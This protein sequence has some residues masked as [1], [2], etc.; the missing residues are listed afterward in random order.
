[1]ENWF[2]YPEAFCD[3]E[4]DPHLLEKLM[5]DEEYDNQVG[6]HKSVKKERAN[7]WD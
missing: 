4:N 7:A 6:V 1:M 2:D 3:L 5:L